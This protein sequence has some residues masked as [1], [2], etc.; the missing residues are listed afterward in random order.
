MVSPGG[1]C[2]VARGACV[3]AL[4]GGMRGC[5]GGGGGVWL[6]GEG[7]VVAWGGHAWDTT[8][9]GDTVNERAVRILLEC[10]LVYSKIYKKST[11][12]YERNF[13]LFE[14]FSYEKFKYVL[15]IILTTFHITY[16]LPLAA[17]ERM[18]RILFLTSGCSLIINNG[19][20]FNA[21]FLLYYGLITLAVSGTGTE[22][23]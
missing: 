17:S 18:Q 8:R 3:V 10:I 12:M 4:G 1:A 2:V 20:Y 19:C 6:L 9:Y 21:I 23:V 5:S 22:V 7:G 14:S 13:S 11:R 16:W 15:G